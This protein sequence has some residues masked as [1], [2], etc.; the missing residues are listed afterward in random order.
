MSSFQPSTVVIWYGLANSQDWFHE[1]CLNLQPRRTTFA[2]E[3]EDEEAE[4]LIPSETYD[5]LVCA[6]CV[7]SHPFLLEKRGTE[8]WMTIVP[9]EKA[10]VV[11]G[12]LEKQPEGDNESK[13]EQ[14]K[15][16]QGAN[17]ETVDTTKGAAE[18]ATATTSAPATDSEN[19]VPNGEESGGKRPLAEDSAPE[20]KR[21]RVEDA[22]DEGEPPK[23]QPSA[24]AA[25]LKAA[26]DIFISHGI[27][28]SLSKTLADD[29]ASSLPF[30]LVDA[31]IYEPAEDTDDDETLEQVTERVVGALPRFQAI[32][33]VHGYQAMK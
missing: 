10:W 25:P 26:G 30:P 29:V 7:E 18:P 21:A 12:K 31:E 22:E 23:S 4:C 9:E 5:G 19:R 27:R 20:A 28:E 6:K 33:A 32:E 2:N 17:K 13:Q 14:Q 11:K 1:S 15:A 16:E 24:P 3:D 8:G